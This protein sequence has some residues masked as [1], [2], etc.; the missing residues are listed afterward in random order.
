[1]GVLEVISV[2]SRSLEQHFEMAGVVVRFE[3]SSQPRLNPSCVLSLR[4]GGVEVDLVVWESGEGEMA[5]ADGRGEVKL[6]H[7]DRLTDQDR[8]GVLLAR[9][10]EFF[11]P[12]N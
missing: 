1:M 8:L 11:P 9:V 6:E 12:Q 4:R 5:L 2:W 7:L 10:L 3:M